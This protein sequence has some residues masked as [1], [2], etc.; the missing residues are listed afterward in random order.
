MENDAVA[1]RPGS[2]IASKLL[3]PLR[4]VERN[5]TAYDL[6]ALIVVVMLVGHVFYYFVPR[7][8]W[9]R[10][11]D[12]MLVPVFLVSVGYNAGQKV[13]RTLWLGAILL[14]VAQWTLFGISQIN[15]L[16]TIIVIRMVI[17]P[18]MAWALKNKERFW[19]LN[20]AL[21]VLFPVTDAVFDYGTMALIMAM[22]GWINRN[23][24]E[25]SPAIVKPSAYFVFAYA[26][27][28]VCTQMNFQFSHAQLL[29]VAIGLAWTMRL[30]YDFR[31]LLM[32]SLRRKPK[33]IVEKFC[34][35]LG[36][37]SLEI[38]VVHVL[39]YQII[40]YYALHPH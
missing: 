36:H 23:R 12:R 7:I 1:D 6:F 26:A 19:I 13:G 34:S 11:V 18:I 31:E 8:N 15:V 30:L 29:V 40:L 25:I 17:E 39:A 2:N 9:L 37:K 4:A 28:L 27:Y 38:Y 14:V 33:D 10:V 32:N 24:E 35:F 20:T 22:A 21:V 5:M 3:R 16:G